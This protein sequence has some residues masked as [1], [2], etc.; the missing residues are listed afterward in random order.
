MNW[1]QKTLRHCS[2]ALAAISAL[3]L[4][5]WA[6]QQNI[7][8]VT[9]YRVKTDRV[10]DLQAAIKEFN[11]VLQKGGSE[12]RYTIWSS[13]SGPNEYLLVRY[14]TKWA[15][16]DVTQ[17][18]KLKEHAAQGVEEVVVMEVGPYA[19]CDFAEALRFHRLK[20]IGRVFQNP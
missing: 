10:G 7:R 15:E 5:A 1:N 8:T 11:G 14:Y 9:R 13:Q 18:P 12:R 16:L 2:F 6:Q 3:C 19:E 17:D 4:P 20:Q